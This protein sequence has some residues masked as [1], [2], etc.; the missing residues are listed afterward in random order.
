MIF[1]ARK[2]AE[3]ITVTTGYADVTGVTWLAGPFVSA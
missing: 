2:S 3:P 1:S